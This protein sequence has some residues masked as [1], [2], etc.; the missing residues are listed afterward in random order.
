[1]EIKKTKSADLESKR[2]TGFLLGLIL[3]L[4]VFFVALEYNA[5]GGEDDIDDDMFDDIA[6]D[7]DLKPRDKQQNMLA[8]VLPKRQQS[9][10][11]RIKVVENH[12]EMVQPDVVN[13]QKNDADGN[14]EQPAAKDEKKD[15]ENAQDFAAAQPGLEENQQTLRVV[16][17]L[18][19][20]P[21]GAVEFMKWLTKNLRY[22]AVAQ[23]NKIQGKVVVQFIINKDGT[24]TD[25]KVVKSAEPSLDREALRV[26]RM[27]P[28]WKPGVEND[29]P[30]R[31]M[32]CIPVVF[33][34]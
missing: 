7:L 13:K 33:A 17:D 29:K 22:P 12:E 24:V 4:S 10:S 11:D 27:M 5:G 9:T 32:V 23:Q 15:N 6:K 28:K 19:Q 31:T 21:G 18:P 14:E 16:E 26:L 3:V 1:M 8:L 2:L 20:F 30:C 25:L 34:L